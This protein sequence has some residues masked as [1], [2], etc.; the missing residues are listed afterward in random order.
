MVLT[1][2]PLKQTESYNGSSWTEVADLN[3]GRAAQ[4]GGVEQ[5]QKLHWLVV[6]QIQLNTENWNG[7]SWTEVNDL[8]TGSKYHGSI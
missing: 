3:T 2:V 8:N 6:I 7:S 4:M 1:L 5:M